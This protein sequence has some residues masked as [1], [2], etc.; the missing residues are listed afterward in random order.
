MEP[1]AMRT[2]RV[3]VDMLHCK[4]Y[5]GKGEAVRFTRWN[6]NVAITS[7]LATDWLNLRNGTMAD[8]HRCSGRWGKYRDSSEKVG[9][10]RSHDWYAKSGLHK[11][12]TRTSDTVVFHIHS[13][14]SDRRSSNDSKWRQRRRERIHWISRRI[15][16]ALSRRYRRRLRSWPLSLPRRR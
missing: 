7:H 6:K 8:H 10:A 2:E 1:Q 12:R 13:L 9:T 4:P 16:R 5:T 3:R 11:F 14:A 15:W